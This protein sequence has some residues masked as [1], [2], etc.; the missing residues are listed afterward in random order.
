M[1][2]PHKV[3]LAFLLS[4]ACLAAAAESSIE[5][6]AWMTGTWAGPL[7]EG[8]LE[9]NWTVPRDGSIQS[10]VR[11]T[12][13]GTT[14]M[15]ELIVIEESEEGLVL[16]LQQWNPGYEPRGPATKMRST[17]IGDREVHFEVVG[18]GAFKKLAYKRPTDDKF[19]IHIDG[20]AMVI[21]L[22]ATSAD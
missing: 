9:E 2:K 18:E 15:V 3:A 16:H 5:K 21:K 1:A 8:T 20:G 6:L 11:M 19:E 17:M 10:V 4:T 13:G 14:A 22:T 12:G 7:G